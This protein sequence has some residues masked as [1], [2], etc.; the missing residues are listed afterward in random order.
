M[1]R[2]PDAVRPWQHVLDP[3]P[4]YLLLA[5]RLLDG[6]AD[7]PPALNFGPDPASACTVAEL[8]EP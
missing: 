4:G 6:P 5:E 3:L 7:A 8:V 2:H 1:L